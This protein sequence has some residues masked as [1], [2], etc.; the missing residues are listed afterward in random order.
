MTEADGR[1]LEK[2]VKQ[3]ILDNPQ[4]FDS[5]GYMGEYKLVYEKMTMR[6]K[7]IA[8][9]MIFTQNKGIIGI[10]IKTEYDTLK[11]LPRQITNYARTCNYV[12][13]Y[14]HDS[15]LKDVIKILKEKGL[16]NIVGIISYTVFDDEVIPGLYKEPARVNPKYELQSA[17]TM[18]EKSSI[19]YLLGM[20]TYTSRQLEKSLFNKESK[21]IGR[22]L[23]KRKLQIS[24]DFV[25]NHYTGRSY[26]QASYNNLI[27]QYCSLLGS[28][29]GTQLLCET[30]MSDYSSVVK[31]I[32]FYH[33]NSIDRGG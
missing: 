31:G 32:N 12:Y 21:R 29:K 1:V 3:S 33:F 16:Y 10:E 9:A 11:R 18:L 8:D 25:K 14:V 27:A 26:P 6:G 22:D 17:L 28:E 7:L 30:M 2:E 19:V 13:V 4:L 5:L 23:I 15:H 20:I 24:H